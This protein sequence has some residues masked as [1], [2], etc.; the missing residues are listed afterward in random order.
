MG[1]CCRV[2]LP[3][4]LHELSPFCVCVFFVLFIAFF[5][6]FL[7]SLHP[8]VRIRE[9][10]TNRLHGGRSGPAL[11]LAA[12]GGGPAWGPAWAVLEAGS[13]WRGAGLEAGWLLP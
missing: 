13:V 11:R 10:R 6:F 8:C 4:R 1:V 3:C 12:S 2:I 9:D 5:V 7:V